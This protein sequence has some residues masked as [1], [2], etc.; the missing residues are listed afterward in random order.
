MCPN[1]QPPNGRAREPDQC[2][3]AS[4]LSEGMT[5]E[6]RTAHL[7]LVVG[8]RSAA[9]WHNENRELSVRVRVCMRGKQ[10]IQHTGST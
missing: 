9:L 3:M 5:K 8:T 7:T 1:R 4:A 2:V 10:C 6:E